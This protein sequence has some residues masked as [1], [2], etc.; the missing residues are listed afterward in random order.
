M[1]RVWSHTRAGPGAVLGRATVGS[2]PD[3]MAFTPDGKRI[4]VANEGEPVDY[5]GTVDPEGSISTLTVPP[6]QRKGTSNR[7][8]PQAGIHRWASAAGVPPA[9][10]ALTIEGCPVPWIA[11]TE[12]RP[13]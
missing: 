7:Q 13:S 9:W 8:A 3:A 10:V 5:T 12:V 2:N 6:G 4:L 11:V 1:S